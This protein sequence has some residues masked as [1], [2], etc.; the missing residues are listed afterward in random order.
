MVFRDRFVPYLLLAPQVA[1]TIVFFIWPA[2]QAIYQSVLR[3]DPFGLSRRFVWFENFDRLFADP[4]FWHSLGISVLFGLAL[5]VLNVAPA[6]AGKG[7]ADE[8]WQT[9]CFELFL[10]P[11]GGAGYVE[12]AIATSLAAGG[13][14]EAD[15]LE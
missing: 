9:T 4:T 3:E 15:V 14:V 12:N 2:G 5:L 11:E 13:T 10:K 6:F 7:R 8:L 1:V